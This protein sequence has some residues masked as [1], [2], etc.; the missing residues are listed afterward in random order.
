MWS[1]IT[2]VVKSW[3]KGTSFKTKYY[4]RLVVVKNKTELK[5]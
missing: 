4:H 1:I 3:Y 2:A 5:K